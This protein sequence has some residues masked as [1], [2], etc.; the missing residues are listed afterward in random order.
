MKGKFFID[1]NIL[2]YL[3]SDTESDKRNKVKT[4][5]KSISPQNTV[6]W[7][8]QVIQEFYQVMTSK[9]GKDPQKV[10]S[11]VRQFSAFELNV[12]NLGTIEQAIDIQTLH[13][14]SFWDSLVISAALQ[15]HCTVLLTE[16]LNHGQKVDGVLIHNP[17]KEKMNL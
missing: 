6:T 3:F 16:D 15:T 17:L 7:S 12:N 10:K 13:K 4:F 1:T 2:L 5:L 9:F 11:I 14:F 8:T